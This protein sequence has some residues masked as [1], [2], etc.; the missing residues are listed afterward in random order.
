LAL[1][2]QNLFDNQH[3]EFVPEYIN[4][5]PSEVVRSMYAKATWK[6]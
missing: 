2:G 3:P 4:T 1:V 6:F 5:R